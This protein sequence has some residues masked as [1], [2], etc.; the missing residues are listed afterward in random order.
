MFLVSFLS[1]V[2]HIHIHGEGH[3]KDSSSSSVLPLLCTMMNQVAGPG[4]KF[5]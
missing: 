4:T 5:P 2:I 1:V 3:E